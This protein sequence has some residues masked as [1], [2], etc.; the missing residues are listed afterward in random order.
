MSEQEKPNELAVTTHRRLNAFTSMQGFE[1][2]QRIAKAIC[3]SSLVPKAYQN[4]IP[5]TVVAM[6]MASRIGISPIMVMQNLD[7][8][9]GKPSWRSTFIISALNACGR[10][11][12]LRFE[13]EGNDI[14]SDD[15]GCRAFTY[16][17]DNPD[18]KIVGPKVDWKMVKAEGWLDKSG[19]K[20]KT[21]PELMFQYR[22]AAFFGRLFA[23]D[24]LTGM[25]SIEEIIDITHQEVEK[26]LEGQN[27]KKERNRVVSFIKLSKDVNT[28]MQCFE[29]IPDDEVMRQYVLKYI[30]LSKT[31]NILSQCFEHIPDEEVEKIYQKKL[32]ELSN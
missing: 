21:M 7:V 15:Y 10:F 27:A 30:E 8:I 16:D 18:E 14:K 4:N 2:A 31:I 9:Q 11:K 28:L 6:E 22:A 1:D 32:K 17:L 25:H 19:S 26:T 29:H 13:F 23:P 12:P 3:Q 24:I 20:W 5:N